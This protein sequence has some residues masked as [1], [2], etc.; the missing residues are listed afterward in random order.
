MITR[1]PFTTP[2]TVAFAAGSGQK[3]SETECVGQLRALRELSSLG[4]RG[5]ANDSCA[6][7]PALGCNGPVPVQEE[8]P[9]PLT[10]SKASQQG[11]DGVPHTGLGAVR[12][13]QGGH[14]PSP[15]AVLTQTL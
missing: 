7:G 2:S 13:G 1:V 4:G 11:G 9:P 10:A 14:L 15:D 3:G 12:G 8:P 6:S 5:C